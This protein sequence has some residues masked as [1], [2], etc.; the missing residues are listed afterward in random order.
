LQ[1]DAQLSDE[2]SARVT[3]GHPRLVAVQTVVVGVLMVVIFVTLLQPESNSPLLGIE[4]PAPITREHTPGP[5]VYTDATGPAGNGQGGQGEPGGAAV[6]NAPGTTPELGL[7][8]PPPAAPVAPRG[9]VGDEQPSPADDQYA[10]SLSKLTS[11][12]N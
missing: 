10:D 1:A 7:T 2:G 12:L 11:R 4:G 5:D 3:G 9:E 6:P 8:G